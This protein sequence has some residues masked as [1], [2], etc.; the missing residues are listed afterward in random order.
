M[1]KNLKTTSALVAFCIL[2]GLSILANP[3]SARP[4]EP[5]SADY[6]EFKYDPYPIGPNTITIFFQHASYCNLYIYLWRFDSR[7]KQWIVDRYT[8]SGFLTYSANVDGVWRLECYMSGYSYY[9]TDETK[10]TFGIPDPEPSQNNLASDWARHPQNWDIY[11]KA[12][13]IINPATSSYDAARNIYYHV[14]NYFPHHRTDFT[15]RSD[16]ALLNDLNT[17]GHYDGVC[18]SDAVILTSYARALGIPA[19]IIHLKAHWEPS[20]N[21][22]REAPLELREPYDDP[23]YFAEF[24]VSCS[25]QY[26]W[27]PVDGDQIYNWFGITEANQKI[28][29]WWPDEL[30]YDGRLYGWFTISIRTI[31]G[32]PSGGIV[33]SGYTTA[34]YLNHPYRNNL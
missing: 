7:V 1:A 2:F 28:S 6:A 19:R 33:D 13:E 24:Y 4:T 31:T 18:R 27:V 32:I 22:P 23:H 9:F 14:V 12:L 5:P 8:R 10:D 30:W 26:Q 3:V 29:L 16:L 34:S 25:G 20:P 15:F 17:Y 21:I 11:K